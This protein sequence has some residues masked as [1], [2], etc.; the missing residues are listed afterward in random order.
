MTDSRS[1]ELTFTTIGV[2]V[3]DSTRDKTK[4]VMENLPAGGLSHVLLRMWSL[5]RR[6]RA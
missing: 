1:A 3:S 6:A 4:T 5:M 2:K